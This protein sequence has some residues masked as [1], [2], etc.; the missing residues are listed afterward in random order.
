MIPSTGAG[1]GGGGIVDKL[2]SPHNLAVGPVYQ[3]KKSYAIVYLRQRKVNLDVP[4]L[5]LAH[6][7]SC[8]PVELKFHRTKCV[9]EN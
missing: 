3:K 7:P 8:L 4:Y 1:V 2:F 9:L 6:I 5:R